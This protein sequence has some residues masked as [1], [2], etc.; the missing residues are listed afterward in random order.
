MFSLALLLHIVIGSTLA[1]TAII[2]SLV[3][4]FDTTMPILLAGAAGF[5]AAVPVSYFVARALNGDH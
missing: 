3:M 2:V 5:I 4:G 1:G